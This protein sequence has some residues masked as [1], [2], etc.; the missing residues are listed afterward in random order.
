[1]SKAKSK[2]TTRKARP[3]IPALCQSIIRLQSRADDESQTRSRVQKA[4]DAAMP[5]PHPSI[6]FG[7]KQDRD[8]LTLSRGC[9]PDAR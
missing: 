5:K 3:S 4:V 2:T 9:N 6:V 8:G 1:M 7:P